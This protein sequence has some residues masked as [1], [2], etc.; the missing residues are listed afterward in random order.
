LHCISP[1]GENDIF[2][3]YY[4]CD[5]CTYHHRKKN[6]NTKS[7]KRHNDKSSSWRSLKRQK[8]QAKQ[9]KVNESSC[10]ERYLL[11][12]SKEKDLLAMVEEQV[13]EIKGLRKILTNMILPLYTEQERWKQLEKDFRQ[14]Q[15]FVLEQLE[16]ASIKPEQASLLYK[17]PLDDVRNDFYNGELIPVETIPDEAN[18]KIVFIVCSFYFSFLVMFIDQKQDSVFN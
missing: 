9:L 8:E 6:A 14:T 3:T 7:S 5:W 11:S 15:D 10:W 18:M 13:A 12:K 4:I 2:I 17:I 1:L 16:S